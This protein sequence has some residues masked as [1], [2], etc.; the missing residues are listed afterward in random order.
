MLFLGNLPYGADHEALKELLLPFGE[1]V[2]LE[3][4]LDRI[5]GRSR[6]FAFVALASAEQETQAMESL[7]QTQWGGRSLRVEPY[8]AKNSDGA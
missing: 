4:V 7:H 5:T 6:G 2:E 1:V 3:L 8:I